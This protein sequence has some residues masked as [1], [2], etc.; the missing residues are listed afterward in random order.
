M[1]NFEGLRFVQTV[2]V[3]TTLL[4]GLFGLLD[5]FAND[6]AGFIQVLRIRYGRF[7]E[8][9]V[10]A[11]PM[12]AM[13]VIYAKSWRHSLFCAFIWLCGWAVVLLSLS[14][15]AFIAGVI[16]HAI[17]FAAVI[18][19]ARSVRKKA[20]TFVAFAIVSTIAI[21]TIF[22]MLT[23]VPTT[24]DLVAGK[25]DA[26]SSSAT[27]RAFTWRATGEMIKTHPLLGVGAG[28]FGPA[29]NDARGRLALSSTPSE[30]PEIAED[31]MAERAH[32]EPIQIVA[33][34]GIVG[35]LFLFGAI[36]VF[37]LGV[38]LMFRRSRRRPSIAFW[39]ALAGMIGFAVSSMVSSFSFRAMQNGIVFFAIL[40]VALNE[41]AKSQTRDLA[42]LTKTKKMALLAATTVAVILL[43]VFSVTRAAA[44]Y[45]VYKAE[46]E[47]DYLQV[48]D[49]MTRAIVLDPDNP[50][51]YFFYA[52]RASI[53]GEN[54]FA[55]NV[56]RQGIARGVGV[57]IAYSRLAKYEQETGD[58]N[59][60]ELT[61]RKGVEIYPNSVFMR[62]R[63]ATFL[64]DL[65]RTG[66][67]DEQ[68]AYAM[69]IDEAQARGWELLIR[70]GSVKAFYTSRSRSGIAEP[71]KLQPANAVL[72]Y[73]DKTA[74]G[75]GE[76][77]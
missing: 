56:L 58:I 68:Q 6:S 15:G 55:A 70:E 39:A 29:F 13:G 8:L 73:I 1:R 21:Q 74:Y 53:A 2:L 48:K 12:L 69:K 30:G 11:L 77:K 54:A 64:R 76:Q 67:A 37:I 38:I 41:I 27:F 47:P 3:I 4:L 40:A 60:A 31:F 35:G 14:R 5:F 57:T 16:A 65:G 71:S 23:A 63:L 19:F 26:R 59:S 22:S 66:V 28:N 75:T 32:N 49:Q 43:S 61:L 72:D 18:L 24:A 36:S 9:L 51:A 25:A 62:M 33:E 50:N 46:R 17:F 42:V 45:F 52:A 44:E 7:A 10:T 20:L 34:L